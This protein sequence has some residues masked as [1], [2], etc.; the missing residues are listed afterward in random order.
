MAQ[1]EPEPELD[2]LERYVRRRAAA[3]PTFPVLVEGAERRRRLLR[4]LAAARKSAGLS[5][6]AV[7]A[8]MRTSESAVARLE[9]GEIDPRVSTIERFAEAVG[10]TLDLHLLDPAS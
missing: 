5:R 8:R 6:T 1:N 7:A 9:G 2:D 3:D 4:E 10:K